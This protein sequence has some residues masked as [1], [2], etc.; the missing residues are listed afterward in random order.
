VHSDERG[1]EFGFHG[2]LH[3]DP[4]PQTIVRTFEHEGTPG[5]V[6]LEKL[7]LEERD[8]GS[9]LREVSAYQSVEDRDTMVGSPWERTY[10]T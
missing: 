9:W 7:T 6:P 5:P 1:N 10:P 2:V 3:R 4:S 8:R